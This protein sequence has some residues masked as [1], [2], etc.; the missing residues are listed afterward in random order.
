MATS[1]MLSK[2][3]NSYPKVNSKA[4]SKDFTQKAQI[5]HLEQSYIV[6]NG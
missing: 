2:A 1:A 6:G 5:G 4:P 3:F